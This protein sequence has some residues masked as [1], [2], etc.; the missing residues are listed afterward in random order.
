MARPKTKNKRINISL[1][2]NKDLNKILENI[3]LCE[4]V[5]KSKF[6]EYIIKNDNKNDRK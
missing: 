1:S 3:V 5:T 6:I 2:I 4:N